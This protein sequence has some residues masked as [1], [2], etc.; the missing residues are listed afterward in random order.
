MQTVTGETD[1][2]ITEM[3]TYDDAGKPVQVKDK[4]AK[5]KARDLKEKAK[6]DLDRAE[7]EGEHLWGIA[8]EQLLRPG[9]AG[10]LV[11]LS[12]SCIIDPL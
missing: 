11:G 7:E 9:V 10:G 4:D 12:T 1:I 5:K 8:K 3:R 6:H 2:N